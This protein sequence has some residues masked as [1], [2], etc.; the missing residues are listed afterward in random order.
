MHRNFASTG[1][2][3]VTVLKD[4]ETLEAQRE[5]TAG[6]LEAILVC[7][8]ITKI[9]VL[10]KQQFHPEL[11]ERVDVANP[12]IEDAFKDSRQVIDYYAAMRS[13]EVI[14]NEQEKISHIAPMLRFV[15]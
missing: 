4:L 9:M 2:D 8:E 1:E 5:K 7:K 6:V 10:A 3:L 15:R 11:K 12:Y 14:K 13:I